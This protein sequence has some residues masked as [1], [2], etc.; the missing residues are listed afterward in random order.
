MALRVRL[1][2]TGLEP[3]LLRK[4]FGE[5]PLPEVVTAVTAERVIYR[6]HPEETAS[7]PCAVCLGYEGMVFDRD[8]ADIPVPPIH[9]HCPCTLDPYFEEGDPALG[10]QPPIE[11]KER[12]EALEEHIE[13]LSGAA[14]ADFVGDRVA[15]LI[16]VGAIKKGDVIRR[17][18]GLR[19]LRV[20]S[21]DLGISPREVDEM[22]NVELR[23]LGE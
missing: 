7:G 9:G 3:D 22:T 4:L 1:Q 13:G 10:G 18:G 16:R 11:P 5:E 21:K 23:R 17:G 20:I 12:Y 2:V 8:D 19:P 6:T 14:L 15:R